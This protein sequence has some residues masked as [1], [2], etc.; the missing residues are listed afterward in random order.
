MLRRLVPV[1]G[2][3][4]ADDLGHAAMELLRCLASLL[5]SERG[6][7]NRSMS[8]CTDD[9][10]RHRLLSSSV[11]QWRHKS[12]MPQSDRENPKGLFH[13]MSATK[14]P[15]K[16]D[17]WVFV[18]TV[19]YCYCTYL[20]PTFRLG[21]RERE[22]ARQTREGQA[23]MDRAHACVADRNERNTQRRSYQPWLQL[24][25]HNRGWNCP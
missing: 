11:G 19:R 9:S 7:S 24:F 20:P 18:A 14:R 2:K 15:R 8:L 3:Y 6:I 13:E 12:H 25:M 16:C 17:P 4:R 22:R 10:S 5:D 21:Y 23:H 1:F